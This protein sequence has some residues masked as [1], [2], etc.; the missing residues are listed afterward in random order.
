MISGFGV[1]L[2]KSLLDYIKNMTYK[3]F[4]FVFLFL[5]AT[6]SSF[7]DELYSSENANSYSANMYAAP[8]IMQLAPITGA[9]NVCPYATNITYSTPYVSGNTYQW[10]VTGGV[11]VGESTGSS[12]IVNWGGAGIGTVT[13]IEFSSPTSSE[14]ATLNVTKGDITDPVII[15]PDSPIIVSAN[16]III[17]LS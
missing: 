15:L 8:A 17:I 11:I 13:V 12:I 14:T 4:L 16:G 1:R 5:L 10:T 3:R 2:H 7:S 6:L 9:D